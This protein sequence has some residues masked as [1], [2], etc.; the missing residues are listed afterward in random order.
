MGKLV[1]VRMGAAVPVAAA[2]S[3]A[4][5]RKPTA[6]R[7]AR[8]PYSETHLHRNTE[9]QAQ[10]TRL[11]LLQVGSQH[12]ASEFHGR[13][14]FG[15]LYLP[16]VRNPSGWKP[17]DLPHRLGKYS[18][19][20]VLQDAALATRLLGHSPPNDELPL[21]V[22]FRRG[23][24]LLHTAGTP[25]TRFLE[26]QLGLPPHEHGR[27]APLVEVQMLVALSH[28]LAPTST[29]RVHQSRCKPLAPANSQPTD[30]LH[31]TNAGVPV[32]EEPPDAPAPAP[33]PEIN[34]EYYTGALGHAGESCAGF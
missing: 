9:T 18:Q 14:A 2:R 15:R 20:R 29:P 4:S 7:G 17:I 11:C 27:S 21:S 12:L 33:P 25:T 23:I 13:A 16:E 32:H 3:V 10:L 24:V 8:G 26:Q 22:V 6:A 5:R 19:E 28:L 30:P 34:Y 31:A 1:A